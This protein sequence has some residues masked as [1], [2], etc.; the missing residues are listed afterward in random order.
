MPVNTNDKSKPPALISFHCCHHANTFSCTS[1]SFCS[2]HKGSCSFPFPSAFL[3]PFLPPLHYILCLS[4][5]NLQMINPFSSS[6]F[7][8]FKWSTHSRP[9][10]SI[11]SNDQPI[12]VLCLQYLQ[13]INPFS[14]SVFNIFKS[15]Q[16]FFSMFSNK[17]LV[18]AVNTLLT[19][20][21]VAVDNWCLVFG[22]RCL[23]FSVW[24]L[25]F[26][27]RCLVLGIRCLVFSIWCLVFGVWYSVFDV[28]SSVSGVWCFIIISSW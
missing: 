21:E 23:V 15:R 3:F 28:W 13:M 12:L 20:F 9:L 18:T 14:S 22:V 5:S 11:S 10:S 27:V 6:V 8:I 1:F 24:C 19:S 16:I 25:V 17:F 2:H 26:G 4:L 7:N